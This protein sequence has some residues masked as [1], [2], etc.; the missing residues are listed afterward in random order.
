MTLVHSLLYLLQLSPLVQQGGVGKY[1]DAANVSGTAM[2]VAP[3]PSPTAVAKPFLGTQTGLVLVSSVTG[4]CVALLLVFVRRFLRR[5]ARNGA[6]GSRKKGFLE[7]CMTSAGGGSG[8]GRRK[9]R[10]AGSSAA[11][12]ALLASHVAPANK[13]SAEEFSKLTGRERSAAAARAARR[14]GSAVGP[15]AGALRGDEW[16]VDLQVLMSAFSSIYSL[17]TNSN[18]FPPPLLYY[19]HL[20]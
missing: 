4:I 14:L 1:Y 15:D 11:R 10:T 20:T 9:W 8:S 12:E 16:L 7:L 2:F 19:S 18:A 17:A 5:R 3:T 6:G 13:A